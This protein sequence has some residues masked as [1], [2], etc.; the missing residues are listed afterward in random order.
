MRG[1][2]EKA[3]YTLGML[4]ISLLIYHALIITG[5]LSAENV[6]LGRLEN[7]E[8]IFKHELA[9][10]LLLLFVLMFM[11][12]NTINKANYFAKYI[13]LLYAV[14]LFLNGIANFFAQSKFELFVFTPLAF[15]M[16]YLFYKI[17]KG[18]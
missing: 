8:E 6:W 11:L 18:K 16:S 17:S 4:I 2:N 14:I 10:I 9:S 7:A 1:T 12:L 13:Y 5:V 3:F 15:F